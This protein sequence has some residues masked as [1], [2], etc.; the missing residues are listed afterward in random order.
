MSKYPTTLRSISEFVLIHFGWCE[1]AVSFTKHR[2]IFVTRF[3]NINSLMSLASVV[4]SV[5]LNP[6]V[7]VDASLV[8]HCLP[9]RE[10]CAEFCHNFWFIHV[11]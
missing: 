5:V 10:W 9:S 4:L 2:H 6:S 3:V 1:D 7:R 11:S 8:F